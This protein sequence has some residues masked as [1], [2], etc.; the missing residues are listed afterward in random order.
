[1]SDRA[2][3]IL[4]LILFLGIVTLIA[5]GLY[6]AFFR[7][8]PSVQEA[9]DD[10]STAGNLTGADDA[11]DD[12]ITDGEPTDDT[13]TDDGVL[14]SSPV[15]DG[16]ATATIVLTN[17]AIVSPT[18]TTNGT[19]AYYDPADG[20]FYTMNSNGEAELLSQAYFPSAETVTFDSDATTAVIEFPD[21]SNVVYD[22]TSG[23]QTTLPSHWEDF[24]FSG[25][26]SEIASKS[27]GNDTSN[28]SLII[29]SADGTHTEVVAALGTNDDAVDVNV[30]PSGSVVAFSSTGSA[31]S[32]D[33]NELYLIGTDG[34]VVG[35]LIVQG[36]NFS[37]IWSPDSTNILYSVADPSNS[38]RPSLWYADS[39]GDRHG[40]VRLHLGPETWVEKC[41]FAS[42]TTVYC[43]VPQDGTDGSGDD[44]TLERG[45]D[46]LYKIALPS[47]TATLVGFAAAETQMFNL[48]VSADGTTLYFQDDVGR[49]LSM[50]LK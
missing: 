50:R 5:V 15:A 41:T 26:G 32:F 31:Q 18:A 46:S 25:D 13:A 27:I 30:S 23:T 28:R 45:N 47:G 14:P 49:L 43:A 34:E 3:V 48:T 24:S 16:G 6:A 1:M 7:V 8:P 19:M 2:K 22:F 21:G 20:H 36:T 38:Y 10:G 42:V 37:A 12:G 39:R 29:S 11:T 44:H 35:S 4:R 33:R 40:D 9:P 17:T